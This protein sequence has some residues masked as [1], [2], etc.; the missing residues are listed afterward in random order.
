MTCSSVFK[1]LFLIHMSFVHF[2]VTII[3]GLIM[4]ILFF[5]E[6]QYYLTKEVG[7]GLNITLLCIIFICNSIS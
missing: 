3:S 1:N 5:S 4:L 7:E 2:V 6:L